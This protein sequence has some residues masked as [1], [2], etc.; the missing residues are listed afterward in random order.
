[1]CRALNR[2]LPISAQIRRLAGPPLVLAI[3]CATQNTPLL[4]Q[5]SAA[6]DPSVGAAVPPQTAQVGTATEATRNT[7]LEAE[8]NDEGIVTLTADGKAFL[9]LWQTDLS[10]NPFG[11]IVIFHGEGQNIDWPESVSVLRNSLAQ[12]GW[13]TLSISLPNPQTPHPPPRPY[14]AQITALDP[15][16][17]SEAPPMTAAN[18]SSTNE[19]K[20]VGDDAENPIP[21]LSKT[22][23]LDDVEIIVQARAKAAMAFLKSKGQYN[24]VFA[25]HGLGAAR[26]SRY[27]DSLSNSSTTTPRNNNRGPKKTQAIIQRPVRALIWVNARNTIP[28]SPSTADA[29]I[30]DWLND[31]G[32]P[33][34]DVYFNTHYLDDIEARVRAKN[35]KLKRLMH[36]SQVKMITPKHQTGDDGNVLSK[37]VRGFLN[38]YAKGVEIDGK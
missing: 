22:H 33:V 7:L 4:A 10:G 8:L 35:T 11:A 29:V 14:A 19:E 15:E 30:T 13:A 38:K 12:F 1:M 36:Y 27:L 32:L 3:L 18:A 31:T 21:A 9:G 17:P 25:G 2:F 34:L 26:A 20:P 24:I 37:R 28:N 6:D 16:E 5:S 23:S